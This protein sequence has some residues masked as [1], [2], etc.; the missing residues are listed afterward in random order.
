MKFNETK[1]THACKVVNFIA[2]FDENVTII[3]DLS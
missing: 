2:M 3:D 1:Y